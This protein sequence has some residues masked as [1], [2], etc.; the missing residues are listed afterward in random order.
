MKKNYLIVVDM[1]KD[2]VD[3]ALGTSEAVSIVPA[4][5]ARV[6]QAKTDGE[7]VIFTRDTHEEHYLNTQEGKNLPV[8][9]CIRGTEGWEIIPELRLYAETV[10]D[11]PTFG[12]RKLGE[13]LA[14]QENVGQ[15]TVIG[16]CT[17]IS[18]NQILIMRCCVMWRIRNGTVLSCMPVMK[19]PPDLISEG[20]GIGRECR[21]IM[22]C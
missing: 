7:I 8:K 13:Y 6:K 5:L 3:G 18:G 10:F 14:S 15:V 11:K 21:Q 12:S 20:G 22:P 1:Q 4:V 19:T 9:H 16:L 2:F 17:D